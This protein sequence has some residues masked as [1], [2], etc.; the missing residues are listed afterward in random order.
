MG[1]VIRGNVQM[2]TI[3]I[4]GNINVNHVVLLIVVHA[5]NLITVAV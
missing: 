1:Y 2:D 4:I 5:I 3:I